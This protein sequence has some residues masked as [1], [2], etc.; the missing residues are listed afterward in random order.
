MEAGMR[1]CKAILGVAAVWLAAACGGGGSGGSQSA[2]PIGT[3]HVELTTVPP[4]VQCIQVVAAGGMKSTT[5]NLAVSV[6]SSS[7]SLNLGR[8]PLGMMQFTASAFDLPCSSISGAAPSWV[9]D[10]LSAPLS[11]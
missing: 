6:G 10:P 1:V 5:T 8:L 7:A 3:A 11:A 9:A 2:E 4:I